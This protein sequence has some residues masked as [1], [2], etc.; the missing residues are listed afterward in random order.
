ML[1]RW[2][3]TSIYLLEGVQHG[4]M[5]PSITSGALTGKVG[6]GRKKSSK[7]AI[8]LSRLPSSS[9]RVLLGQPKVL[10]ATPWRCTD[11]IHTRDKSLK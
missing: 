2:P 6:T 8:R 7:V 11:V 3:C 10:F 9:Q 4:Q 1:A 5:H